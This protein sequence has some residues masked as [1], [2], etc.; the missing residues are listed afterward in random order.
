MVCNY[1]IRVTLEG[2]EKQIKRVFIINENVKIVDFCKA[3]IISMNGSL[4]HLYELKY[5]NKYYICD[6]M[7]K[8]GFDEIK[9]RSQRIGVLVLGEKDKLE[10]TYDFGDNWVFKIDVVKVTSGHHEKNIDLIDGIG[11]GIEEDCGGVWGLEQ[12]I[13]NKENDWDYDYNDFNLKE[14]SDKLDRLFNKV[15]R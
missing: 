3:V 15:V 4:E 6:Y 2:V 13:D 5:K 9:M 7:E 1:K 11:R 14:M 8:N 12:L 10:L